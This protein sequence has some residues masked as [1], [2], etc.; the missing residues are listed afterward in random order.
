V[1]TSV[2]STCLVDS[3][4]V[5]EH[6]HEVTPESRAAR[7]ESRVINW[8][9]DLIEELYP[10]LTSTPDNPIALQHA[11]HL[12]KLPKTATKSGDDVGRERRVQQR[13]ATCMKADR[14]EKPGSQRAPKTLWTCAACSPAV[15]CCNSEKSVCFAEHEAEMGQ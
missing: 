9:C 12:V 11:C 1:A 10:S 6:F 7:A 13:R 14:K 4:N 15:C 3:F 5:W 2:T 8:T